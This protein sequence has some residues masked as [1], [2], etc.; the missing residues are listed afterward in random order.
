MRSVTSF[1]TSKRFRLQSHIEEQTGVTREIARTVDE[2]SQAAREVATQI[3]TVSNEAIETGR[4]AS[5]IRDGAADIAGKVD[6]LRS[7]LVR[8]IRTSTADVDRRM[9]AR[10]DI[11]RQGSA[12]IRGKT[13]RVA[14]RDLSEGSAM[15][16]GSIAEAGINS[17]VVLLIDGIS[18]KLDGVIADPDQTLIKFELSEEAVSSIRKLAEPREAA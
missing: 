5:E 7:I 17:P 13:V 16:D 4:R 15:I 2:T 9:F 11:G 14:V 6:S 8:V 3:V 10:L 18:T 1:A 12:T